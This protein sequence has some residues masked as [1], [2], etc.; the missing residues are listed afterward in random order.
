MT[1]RGIPLAAIA[2]AVLSACVSAPELH[3]TTL[4]GAGG[5]RPTVAMTAHGAVLAA[6][7][8]SGEMGGNVRLARADDGMTFGP[9][10]QVNDIE[11]DAAPHDQAPAQVSG[12]PGDDVYV[13]W[14]NNTPAE[15][16]L[17]GRVVH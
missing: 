9:P 12:G 16:R 3:E 17:D 15:G 2:G 5:S 6:W 11:G 10:I 8:E 4:A 7:V 14:Q 1:T 13:V